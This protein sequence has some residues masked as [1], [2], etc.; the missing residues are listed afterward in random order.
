MQ[1]SDYIYLVLLMRLSIFVDCLHSIQ[2]LNNQ[3]NFYAWFQASVMKQLRTA[4]F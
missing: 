2:W 1:M 4:L 3:Y